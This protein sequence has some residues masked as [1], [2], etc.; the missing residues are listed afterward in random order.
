MQLV[1]M[2]SSFSKNF[3]KIIKEDPNTALLKELFQTRAR[4]T[5]YRIKSQVNL[6]PQR[7]LA[8]TKEDLKRMTCGIY[9]RT[10]FIFNDLLQTKE[11]PIDTFYLP[12]LGLKL[13]KSVWAKYGKDK[14]GC[15]SDEDSSKLLVIYEHLI[16]LALH[17]YLPQQREFGFVS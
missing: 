16:L 1:S 11:D 6:S 10:E 13:S 17:Y 7:I 8:P 3:S 12:T 5:L 9:D 2:M 4:E 15:D 14:C